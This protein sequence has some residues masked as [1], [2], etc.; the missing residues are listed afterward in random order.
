[1]FALLALLDKLAIVVASAQDF[2]NT[3]HFNRRLSSN[4]GQDGPVT[5]STNF[6]P[7]LDR[8]CYEHPQ[9][10]RVRYYYMFSLMLTYDDVEGAAYPN[11]GLFNVN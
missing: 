3:Y 1:M 9:V 11:T 10:R 2:I 8:C 6:L 5:C 7:L 4:C